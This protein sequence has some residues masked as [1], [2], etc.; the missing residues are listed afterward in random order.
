MKHPPARLF[1]SLF[2]S[3][4]IFPPTLKSAFAAASPIGTQKNQASAPI[5][6]W[7]EGAPGALGIEDKDKPTLTPYLPDSAKAT[8]AAVVICP[9]GGYE[10]LANHEGDH[11]ARFLAEYG[12]AGFVLKYRLGSDGY[13]HPAMLQDAARA[14]RTVRAQGGRMGPRSQT[15]RH[16]GLFR[17]R[18]FGLH[19]VDAFRERRSLRRRPHRAGQQPAGFG[20]SL[21]RRHHHGRVHPSG[22]ESEL[23][24]KGSVSGDWSGCSPTSF[25]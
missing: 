12:I 8:G 20:D 13:R 14:V 21:L 15:D 5:L 7:P 25:R 11:Y 9:G 22:I 2:L 4:A 16:H 24:R 23:A 18:P 10:M 6:L 1:M 19:V 17:G 3:F